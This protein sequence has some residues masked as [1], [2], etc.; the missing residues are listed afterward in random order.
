MDS[1]SRGP[2]RHR[3]V[4]EVDGPA[5]AGLRRAVVRAFACKRER[6]L[7]A[8]HPG[9][10]VRVAPPQR[11]DKRFSDPCERVRTRRKTVYIYRS[12]AALL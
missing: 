7:D 3:T 8:K 11:L 6:A 9:V 12:R 5:L 4:G 1:Q 10:E 2:S